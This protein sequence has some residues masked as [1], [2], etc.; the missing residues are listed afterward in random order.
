M[1]KT[2]RVKQPLNRSITIACTIFILLLSIV[3]SAAAIIV[4]RTS[5]YARYEKQMESILNYVEAHIDH[6]DMAECARTFVKS[7]KYEQF[8][9][10][11]PFGVILRQ[12]VLQR[13]MP[14]PSCL[15]LGGIGREKSERRVPFPA[16]HQMEENPF[17]HLQLLALFREIQRDF[18]GISGNLPG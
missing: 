3:L 10:F 1:N 13:H 6:D 15:R 4:I 7:E 5:M 17:R 12:R 2:G 14:N 9:Q 16:F 18:S 11:L 8:Q